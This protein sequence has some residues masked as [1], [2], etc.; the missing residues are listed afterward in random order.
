MQRFS[1]SVGKLDFQR[2]PMEIAARLSSP[3]IESVVHGSLPPTPGYRTSGTKRWLIIIYYRKLSIWA[4]GAFCRDIG[5]LAA[6]ADR[7]P[8]APGGAL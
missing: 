6:V 7:P 3:E 8:I 1:Q 5:L 4:L 2:G